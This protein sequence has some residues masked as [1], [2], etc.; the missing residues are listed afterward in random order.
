MQTTLIKEEPFEGRTS[1]ELAFG[2]FAIG[3]FFFTFLLT[4]TN[5]SDILLVAFVFIV[6]AV[7][8]NVIMLIHLLYHF[9]ILP[10]QR[11]YIGIKITILLSNIP[12]SILYFYILN[13][14]Q[15]L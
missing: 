1:T 2:C 14:N 5:N 6:F 15:L 11:K 12:V 10:Q 3:T 8:L 13:A 4:L 9:Y 7:P